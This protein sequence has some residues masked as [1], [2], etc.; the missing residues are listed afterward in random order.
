MTAEGMSSNAARAVAARLIGLEI[1]PLLLEGGWEHP[2]DLHAFVSHSSTVVYFYPG[3]SSS[4]EDDEETALLDSA[5]HRAFRDHQPD[6][7]ARGYLTIAI[8]SQFKHAQRQTALANR[9]TDSHVLLCD[10]ELQLEQDLGLPKFTRYGQRWYQ[11]LVLVLISARIEKA[12]FPVPNASR[13]AAQVIAW[14]MLQS[15]PIDAGNK[16]S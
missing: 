1:P 9:V 16:A 10:P 12:F 6:F 2:M 14:M 7:E 8:S 13:S 15:I 5:Q 11:R 3:C 4:P